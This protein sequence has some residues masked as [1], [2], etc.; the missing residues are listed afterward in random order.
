M[1]TAIPVSARITIYNGKERYSNGNIKA[2]A[3]ADDLLDFA[4]AL[5]D[6]QYNGPADKFTLST[7]HE[8]KNS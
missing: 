3:Q 5:N 8:L 1:V 4:E 2:D 6:L 7:K